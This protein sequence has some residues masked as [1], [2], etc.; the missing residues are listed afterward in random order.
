MKFVLIASDLF[1]SGFTLSTILLVIGHL[2]FS[3]NDRSLNK[4]IVASNCLLLTGAF[5]FLIF[6]LTQVAAYRDNINT[7]EDYRIKQGK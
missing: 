4:L 1:I 2:I 3:S 5:L 6:K 7:T